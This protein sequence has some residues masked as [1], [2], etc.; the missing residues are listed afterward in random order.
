MCP[1]AFPVIT[2]SFGGVSPRCVYPAH[3]RTASV[4]RRR[5]AHAAARTTATSTT[6][7]AAIVAGASGL[8]GTRRGA[9]AGRAV[10]IAMAATIAAFARIAEHGPRRAAE[11]V[12]A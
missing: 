10:Q 7:A 3:Q 4:L 11:E 1:A 9:L 5:R 6:A 2:P 8:T 12:S